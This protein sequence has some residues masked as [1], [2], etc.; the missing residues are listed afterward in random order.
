MTS[1]KRAGCFTHELPLV[2]LGHQERELEVA[3]D[4]ARQASNALLGETLRRL[5]LMR[6]RKEYGRARKMRGRSRTKAFQSVRR[7]VGFSQ[8]E[9]HGWASRHLT[10]TWLAEHLDATVVRSLS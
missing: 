1:K 5:D 6:E 9:I 2:L 7:E 8:Y 10:R 4:T 3:F